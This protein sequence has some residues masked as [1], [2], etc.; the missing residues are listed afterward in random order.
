MALTDTLG[1][2]SILPKTISIKPDSTVY[3]PGNPVIIRG[4]L[5]QVTKNKEISLHANT[6]GEKG[7]SVVDKKQPDDRGYFSFEVAPGKNTTY[8]ASYKATAAGSERTSEPI[9]IHVRPELK[10][11]VPQKAYLE[12]NYRVALSVS[13]GQYSGNSKIQVLTEK[14]W[15]DIAKGSGT[16]PASYDFKADSIGSFK[17]R[18]VVDASKYSLQNTTADAEVTIEKPFIGIAYSKNTLRTSWQGNF[19]TRRVEII[20]EAL[21][22]KYSKA[23]SRRINDEQLTNVDELKKYKIVILTATTSTS[24][25]QRAAIREYVRQ[26]GNIISLFGVGRNDHDGIPLIL[27]HQFSASWDLSRFWEWE[28]LSDVYQLKFND[29]PLMYAKYKVLSEN[30]DHPIINDT[31]KQLGID[32]IKMQG[33]RASYNELSWSMKGNRNVTPIL[34]YDTRSNGYPADDKSHGFPAAWVSRFYKGKAVYYTFILPEFVSK[35]NVKNTKVATALLHNTVEWLLKD[36]QAG[37]M[38]K[39]PVIKNDVSLAGRLGHYALRTKQTVTNAGTIQLR[40]KYWIKI[41][42][43]RKLIFNKEMKELVPLGPKTSWSYNSW[44][45]PVYLSE[46]PKSYKI[47][48]GFTYHDIEMPGQKNTIEQESRYEYKDGTL[49]KVSSRPSATL[50]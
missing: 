12:G 20:E 45:M 36:Q 37:E 42:S 17:F 29:D 1:L 13:P 50:R 9:E 48:T 15:K 23:V 35:K 22:E 25:A 2:T 14:G 26:G 46:N 47:V 38:I 27:K 10:L 24:Q 34:L 16:S 5:V 32:K 19:Y 7:S 28:E 49:K 39:K 30:L 44:R 41:Y 6:L 40:G 8:R 4:K 18:G 33:I 21:A 31:K 43:G 3:V 11:S